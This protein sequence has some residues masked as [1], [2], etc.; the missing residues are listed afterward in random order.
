MAIETEHAAIEA[1]QL[2]L[3][4]SDFT[5]TLRDNNYRACV[6]S[7]GFIIKVLM[8]WCTVF[9][10]IL[11][12]SPSFLHH[13]YNIPPRHRYLPKQAEMCVLSINA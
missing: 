8:H 5:I 2:R 1:E 12:L 3:D 11:V 9:P 7:Q 4:H 6:S 10:S 13:P